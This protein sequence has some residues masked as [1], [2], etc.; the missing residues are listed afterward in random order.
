MKPAALNAL[1]GLMLGAL[2]LLWLVSSQTLSVHELPGGSRQWYPLLAHWTHRLE[3]MRLCA[4]AT[5]LAQVVLGLWLMERSGILQWGL[6]VRFRAIE[7]LRPPVLKFGLLAFL[8]GSLAGTVVQH[9]GLG[10]DD[11][12]IL[13]NLR[14]ILFKLLAGGLLGYAAL[15]ASRSPAWRE[16]VALP[17]AALGLGIALSL[18]PWQGLLDRLVFGQEALRYGPWAYLAWTSA[19]LGLAGA[20]LGWLS[21]REV[22]PD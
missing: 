10:F 16:R 12:A 8:T 19:C 18:L 3:L 7:A 4:L 13:I 2:M 17:A 9:L 6:A 5:V 21:A 15:T 20:G 11:L 1:S 22:R 14:S